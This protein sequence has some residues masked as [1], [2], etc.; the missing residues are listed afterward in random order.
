MSDIQTEQSAVNMKQGCVKWFNNKAGYG[1]IT[2]KEGDD[3]SA[4]DIFVHHSSLTC[5]NDQYKYL[6]Q[7]EYVSFNLVNIDDENSKHKVKADNVSGPSGGKLMCET[8][9]RN[10]QRGDQNVR[11]FGNG[12]RDSRSVLPS[13]IPGHDW[14]LMKRGSKSSSRGEVSQVEENN[15]V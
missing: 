6:V 8:N 13:H 5:D 14:V 9:R 12:P 1:F 7:G 3:D 11:R 4:T 10:T 15:D 2:M